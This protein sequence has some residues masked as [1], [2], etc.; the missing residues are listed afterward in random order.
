MCDTP[1]TFKDV[2]IDNIFFIDARYDCSFDL[3]FLIRFGFNI[4]ND[5]SERNI[6]L[7]TF[8]GGAGLTFSRPSIIAWEITCRAQSA[9]PL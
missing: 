8:C 4:E 1:A 2:K 6:H 3:K 9:L 7:F 5:S